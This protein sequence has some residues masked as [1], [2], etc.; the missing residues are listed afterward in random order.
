M[1]LLL[2]GEMARI[3]AAML[4]VEVKKE[5]YITNNSIKMVQELNIGESLEFAADALV[6]LGSS[7][8]IKESAK[9]EMLE[10]LGKHLKNCKCLSA[11]IEDAYRQDKKEGS[12]S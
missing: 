11:A 12:G 10:I 2:T 5:I 6:K 7:K 1:N 3:A 8:Q 9:N 4:K